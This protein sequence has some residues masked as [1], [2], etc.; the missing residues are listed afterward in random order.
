MAEISAALVKELREK[1]GAGV[2]DC[3]KALTETEGRLDVAVDWLR[4]KGITVA[5]KKAS[6]MAAEGLIGVASTDG[7]ATM[8]EINSETDFVAHNE[9]FQQ[10]VKTVAQLAL[11][12]IPRGIETTDIETLK[13][14]IYPVTGRTVTEELA[15]LVATTGENIQVRR[16][17]TLSVPEGIV[18]SYVHNTVAPGIGKISALVAL[19][20]VGDKGKLAV[21]GRKLAMHVAAAAPKFLDIASV[22]KATLDRE[23]ALLT[24][25]ARSSGKEEKLISKVVEGRLRKYYE[26]VVLLEQIYAIDGESRISQVL[27]T[28]AKTVGAPIRINSFNRFGLGEEIARKDL[29]QGQRTLMT[30]MTE[31]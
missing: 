27:E 28:A 31:P 20:S 15:Q 19:G 9:L 12:I 2:M 13:A 21:F 8:I 22:D 29:A 3:K 25:H 26:D 24:E 7:S 16:I 5:A 17:C 6:R 4:R 11:T 1:T 14:L 10:F 30:S 23:R 18:A